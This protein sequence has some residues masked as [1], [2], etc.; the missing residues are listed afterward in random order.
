MT[1]LQLPKLHKTVVKTFLIINISNS[2]KLNKFWVGIFTSHTSHQSSLLNRSE[3]V[4]QLGSESVSEWQALPMIGLGSDKNDRVVL[5]S[6]KF[7]CSLHWC[8]MSVR[9]FLNVEES[10]DLCRSLGWSQPSLQWTR[11]G[12]YGTNSTTANGSNVI[13]IFAWYNIWMVKYFVQNSILH[14]WNEFTFGPIPKRRRGDF[15]LNPAKNDMNPHFF[16]NKII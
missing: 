11:N 4:S 6:F 2:N 13:W 10:S 16:L 3:S 5:I 9:Q 7:F 12:H 15:G 1:K 14:V 8:H